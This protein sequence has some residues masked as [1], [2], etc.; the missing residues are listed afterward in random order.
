MDGMTIG[1]YAKAHGVPEDSLRYQVT[2]GKLGITPV[3]AIK[4]M[5]FYNECDLEKAAKKALDRKVPFVRT[6][7]FRDRFYRALEATYGNI[8]ASCQKCG[9]S[10]QEVRREMGRSQRFAHSVKW[11]VLAAKNRVAA[12]SKR[13]PEIILEHMP[14]YGSANPLTSEHIS[15][16]IG[17]KFDL[18]HNTILNM[19]NS[20][21]IVRAK[22]REGYTRPEGK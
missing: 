8:S 11:R 3:C 21:L 1:D 4:N 18:V 20:G 2:K 13:M 19:I 12:D 9:V 10:Q 16:R 15:N 6:K 7:V 17:V 22:R 5:R 14:R